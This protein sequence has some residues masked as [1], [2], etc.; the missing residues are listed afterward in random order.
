MNM[1]KLIKATIEETKEQEANYDKLRI[2]GV[3]G[4]EAKRRAFQHLPF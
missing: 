2:K 1:K 3:E 4:K